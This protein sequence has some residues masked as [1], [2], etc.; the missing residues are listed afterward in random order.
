MDSNPKDEQFREYVLARRGVLMREAYLLTG[1][2]QQAED[3][4]QTTLAK[5]YVSWH[6]VRSSTS[7]D[8]YVRRILINTNIST[9][10]RR[11][12][13]E[14]LTATAPEPAAPTTPEHEW[15]PELIDALRSLPERQ[16]AVVVLRY[17]EGL[18][19]AEIAEALGCTVG[20]VRSHTSRALKRLRGSMHALVGPVA[21]RKEG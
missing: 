1:D 8:A 4:V 15:G 6:R 21:V 7:P 11:R 2:P 18:P 13:R 14:V 20:T 10:R 3:L 5:T 19:E 17:W 16:R 12:I 9:F